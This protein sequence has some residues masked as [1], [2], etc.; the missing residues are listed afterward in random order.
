MKVGLNYEN[1][2]DK[3]A[4]ST[5]TFGDWDMNQVE[6]GE[7]GL[8]YYNNTATDMWAVELEDLRYDEKVVMNY[9]D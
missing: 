8:N 5:I 3:S 7:D 2:N 9:A 6:G 1:P 4:V